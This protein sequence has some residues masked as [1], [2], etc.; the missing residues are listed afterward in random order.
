MLNQDL[1]W[2][3]NPGNGEVAQGT[4]GGWDSRMGPYDS[5][6]EAANALRIARARTA[7]ADAAE[8]AEDDWGASPSW[9]K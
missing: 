4:Q 8:E 2:Y 9:E 5:R 1:K 3:Y 6:E 7:A